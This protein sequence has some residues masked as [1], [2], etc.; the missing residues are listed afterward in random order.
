M[1]PEE[2]KAFLDAESA[3]RNCSAELCL[4]R[5]DPLLV[6]RMYL[7][8]HFAL[9]C[10]LFAY[11]NAKAIVAFLSTLS[12]TLVDS[13][14][15]TLRETLKGTYYRFQNT[16]DIVQWFVTLRR[17]RENGG[18]EKAF[19]R[20]YRPGNILSGTA[21]VIDELYRLNPYRS[22]GYEFLIG[23]P[24]TTVSKASAMKR[25]MMYLRWMVRSDQLD[26][27]LWNGVDRSDL[28]MPLDT[29]TFEVSR[30][31]GLLKRSQCDFRAAL[32][33]TQ[34]LKTFDPLDPVRYD[35]ALYRLGQEKVLL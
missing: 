11:G 17:L 28:V 7:E 31:F 14:E 10:A 16:E 27:G 24:V 29:H 20:G 3:R 33:L 18:V 25:W 2:I 12:P 9:T 22:R 4:E 34:T 32:E 8:E 21:A 19:M 5:P 30:R 6:A 23:K 35:F 26:I 1:T 15:R 13:D